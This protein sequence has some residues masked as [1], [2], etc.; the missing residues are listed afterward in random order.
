[1][2]TSGGLG[3]AEVGG[4]SMNIVPKEGGNAI[5]GHLHASGVSNG[6]DR[7]QL[8]AGTAG[9]RPDHAG[10]ATPRSGTSTSAS[11]GRSCGTAS[12]TSAELRDEGSERSVPGMFANV[13]AGDPT[14]WTYVADTSRPA[15]YAASY[16][17]AVAAPDRRR[18]RRAT[19]STCSGTSSGRARAERPT[20]PATSVGRVPER[21]SD[22][23]YFAGAHG[24]PHAGGAARP[25]RRKRRPIALT[26]NRVQQAKWTSPVTQPV[27]ARKP[28]SASTGAAMVAKPMPGAQ[29]QPI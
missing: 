3:E 1:M 25:R 12:G 5:A 13:N 15:V 7:Q 2:I 6:D 8:L 18:R 20:A 9:P 23:E 22:G 14:K 16:R 26:G 27:A 28:A 19:S 24:S 29:H 11:A 10:R 4:P 17:I 21:S